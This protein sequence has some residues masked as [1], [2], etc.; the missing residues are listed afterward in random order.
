M[1]K[2]VEMSCDVA[3]PFDM[4][5]SRDVNRVLRNWN[6]RAPPFSGSPHA[7]YTAMKQPSRRTSHIAF[8]TGSLVTWLIGPV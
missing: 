3:I 7:K 6:T 5:N 1:V 4:L 2:S 8:V